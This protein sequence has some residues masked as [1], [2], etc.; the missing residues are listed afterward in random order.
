MK[1]FCCLAILAISAILP[2]RLH[3][4]DSAPSTCFDVKNYTLQARLTPDESKT[5]AGRMDVTFRWRSIADS[6]AFCFHLK[7]LSMDS[8][9][10][11]GTKLTG[12]SVHNDITDSTMYSVDD[13]S[14][15][16]VK[17]TSIDITLSIY[18]HGK[19]T[20][21]SFGGVHY[22]NNMLYSLGVGFYYKYVSA[23]R[24]WM[25]CFD[26]PSDKAQ[27][28]AYYVIPKSYGYTCVSNGLEKNLDIE[29]DEALK[30]SPDNDTCF[31]WETKI[32]TATYLM[33]FTIGRLDRIN[34]GTGMLPM[35]VYTDTSLVDASKYAYKRLPEM[36]EAFEKKLSP[37]PFE[38]VG[39]V[40][41]NVGSME[42]QTMINLASDVIKDY[43]KRKDTISTT[44]AHEL[45]HQWFGDL[46]TPYDFKDA[47]LNESFATFCEA[48]WAES[49]G[50]R[51]LY[52]ATL[53]NHKA[54][55]LNSI[56]PNEGA[57]P[58]YDFPR[59]P[60]SS[61]YPAT[62]YYKGSAVLGLLRYQAGDEA[63]FGALR[64]YLGKHG[65]ANV[66]TRDIKNELEA[67]GGKSLD[68]FFNEW[69]YRPGV[70]S[71]KVTVCYDYNSGRM[72]A[73]ALNISQI[74]QTEY[75]IYTNLPLEIDFAGADSTKSAL[76]VINSKDTLITLSPAIEFTKVNLNESAEF[77]APYPA[78]LFWSKNDVIESKAKGEYS[79]Y[80][81]P[82]DKM[83]TIANLPE[84]EQATID[85]IDPKGSVVRTIYSNGTGELTAD[86]SEI[87]TG[88]YFALIRTK[89]GLLSKPIIVWH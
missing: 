50:G 42:H 66:C 33:T 88:A 37:F 1:F 86:C 25:P 30:F 7:D 43:Y 49:I 19:M 47:W 65:F 9:L 6:N 89:Y 75:G 26:K 61:N 80:P 59:T 2:A 32:P 23:A 24:H 71:I 29:P 64:S 20:N 39:Y 56:L 17:D 76:F 41:T 40:N 10:F 51:K 68:D 58:L 53:G 15:L 14:I 78:Y 63:F 82:A 34:F 18:Y 21:E 72:N 27:F 77:V 55:Y 3:A 16:S 5:V 81:C 62:I 70:P 84:G 46:V 67:A 45:A 13:K 73:T 28:K 12:I 69:I 36:V 83:L 35:A 57:L 54:F 8:V 31:V 48:L 52:L 38:K 44:I 4:D 85:I 11:H 22:D 79:I 74:Q 60:P 87:S